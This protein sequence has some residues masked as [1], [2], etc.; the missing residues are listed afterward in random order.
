MTEFYFLC[1]LVKL[2]IIVTRPEW[3][4]APSD[5]VPYPFML[6]KY[7]EQLVRNFLWTGDWIIFNSKKLL[8]KLFAY[9]K[10]GRSWAEKDYGLKPCILTET[11]LGN[12]LKVSDV[13]FLGS[14]YPPWLLVDL[15]KFLKLRSLA[16]PFLKHSV[17]HGADTH[18]WF[19]RW[20]QE[21]FLLR[22]LLL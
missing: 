7:I 12:W 22:G 20:H 11:H 3:E 16:W 9:L 13:N 18:L 17:G 8:G 21:L 15:V 4:T 1:K 10:R 14:G 2:E 19:D 5:S 6:T